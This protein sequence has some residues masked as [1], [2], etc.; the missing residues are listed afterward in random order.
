MLS[1]LNDHPWFKPSCPFHCPLCYNNSPWRQIRRRL[2]SGHT[3]FARARASALIQLF[4]ICARGGLSLTLSTTSI[5]TFSFHWVH[6]D[7]ISR[8][9]LDNSSVVVWVQPVHL[10]GLFAWQ[11]THSNAR[12]GKNIY[13]VMTTV[14]IYYIHTTT[15]KLYYPCNIRNDVV[16]PSVLP[17]STVQWNFFFHIYDFLFLI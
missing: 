4:K 9:V 2:Q 12:D 17:W 3:S 8:R 14:T 15:A 5:A 13:W 6:L 11:K 16:L 10:L 7:P 1:E